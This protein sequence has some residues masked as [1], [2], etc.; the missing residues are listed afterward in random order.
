MFCLPKTAWPPTSDAAEN[1]RLQAMAETNDGFKLAELDLK[2][3]GPGEFLGTR[4]SG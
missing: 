4:Q 1:E 3:R 2:Q